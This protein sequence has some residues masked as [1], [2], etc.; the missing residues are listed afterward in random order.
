MTIC[1][2]RLLCGVALC[3]LSVTQAQ[4]KTSASTTDAT[5]PVEP[6]D[7]AKKWIDDNK[8]KVDAWLG[9]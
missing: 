4:A 1:V 9:Q 3:V 7:A 5:K 8:D 6:E 2:P